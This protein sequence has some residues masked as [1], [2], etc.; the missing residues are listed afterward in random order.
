[1]TQTDPSP[2]AAAAVDAKLRE[3]WAHLAHKPRI[4]RDLRRILPPAGARVLGC[5]FAL[6]P[7]DNWTEY[8]IWRDGRLPEH[9]A[10][11]YLCDLYAG[12]P[13]VLV[14]VGANAGAFSLP[15]LRAA[16]PGSRALLFEPNPDMAA[17]LQRNIALNRIPGITLSPMAVSDRNGL[18]QLHFPSYGNHGQGRVGSAYHADGRRIDV[19]LRPLPDCLADAA[20]TRIDLLKVD[21]EGL[22]DRVIA[23]LLQTPGA[24]LPQRIYFEIEHRA[25]WRYPLFDLLAG[26]GYER[27]RDFGDNLLFERADPG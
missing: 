27:V 17:R 8:I 24:P 26:R 1:M 20:I 2:D 15:I 7:S 18:E 16:G 19:T 25:T 21:V 6:T 23:P 22:E 5:D 3:I 13:M 4:L 9:D 11:A 12:R 14:D 10:T